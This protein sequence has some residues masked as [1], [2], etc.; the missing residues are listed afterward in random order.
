MLY[1]TYVHMETCAEQGKGVIIRGIV[2][3]DFF[4]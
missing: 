3:K 4:Q 2:F 1:I